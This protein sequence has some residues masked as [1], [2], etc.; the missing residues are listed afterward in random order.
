MGERYILQRWVE[1]NITRRGGAPMVEDS[2][3][4]DTGACPQGYGPAIIIA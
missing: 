2:E 3:Q 4:T 1:N